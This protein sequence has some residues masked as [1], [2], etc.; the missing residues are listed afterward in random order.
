MCLSEK[1]T[2]TDTYHY[3][4]FNNLNNFVSLRVKKIQKFEGK[5]R[6]E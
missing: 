4:I 3:R 2:S 5:I 6:K 1:T